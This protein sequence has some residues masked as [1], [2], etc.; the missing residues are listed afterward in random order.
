MMKRHC[1]ICDEIIPTGQSFI[2][3]TKGE[4]NPKSCSSAYAIKDF[5][6]CHNCYNAID[7]F[8]KEELKHE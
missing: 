5:D 4:V 3:M 6:I 8:K 2:K 7:F 1:D